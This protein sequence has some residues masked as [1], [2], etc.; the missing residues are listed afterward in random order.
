MRIAPGDQAIFKNEG[1]AYDARIVIFATNGARV[2]MP[3]NP[4]WQDIALRLA[5]TLIAGAVIGIDRGVRGHVAGLRTTM[6]VALA[7]ALA[8]IQ[9]NI[10][11][12][13]TGKT[14][15]SFGEM[16]LMRLP[17]GILTGVGFIGGGTILRRGEFVTGV[18]TAATLW[19]VT[20]IGLCLG[21]DQI[22]LGVAG[23]ILTVL[24]LS[25]LR[26]FDARI[27]R[28]QRVLLVVRATLGDGVPDR[29][30]ALLAPLGYH[31]LLQRQSHIGEESKLWFEILGKRKE[32]AGP[33]L[34]LIQRVNEAF[35]VAA[36]DLAGAPQN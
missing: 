28:E 14:P 23:T 30:N 13:V 12:P 2:Q 21:G 32:A 24:T 4:T 3:L 33:P 18:T 31:A 16:D 11:L 10:L 15:A 7:A 20:V 27:P 34:E 36:F 22:Y 25:A 8:M 26:W 1:V 5:L 9:A 6:L 19:V 17:L 35:D 29:L